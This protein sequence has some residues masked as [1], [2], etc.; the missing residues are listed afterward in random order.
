MSA[1]VNLS[2]ESHRGSSRT[3]NTR[4]QSNRLESEVVGSARLHYHRRMCEAHVC[5]CTHPPCTSIGVRT[6]RLRSHLIAAMALPFFPCA[7]RFSLKAPSGRI[8]IC[9]PPHPRFSARFR[10]A[11]QRSSCSTTTLMSFLFSQA[12]Y[13]LFH[14]ARHQVSPGP[15]CH[16]ESTSIR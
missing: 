13:A 15:I 4:L 11:P 6:T 5:T 16:R 14:A 3:Y 12:R 8:L 1:Q 10:H 9:Q 7:P 2:A